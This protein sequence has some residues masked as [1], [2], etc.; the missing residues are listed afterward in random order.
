MCTFCSAVEDDF[1]FDSVMNGTGSSPVMFTFTEAGEQCVNISIAMD[2]LLETSEHFFVVMGSRDDRVKLN[3]HISRIDIIDSG[4][5]F[6]QRTC[7]H[8]ANVCSVQ[9]ECMHVLH[10]YNLC[11]HTYN[12]CYCYPQ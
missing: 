9:Y 11:Y 2:N 6:M 8:I 5:E 7:M 3:N 1:S 12:G 4:S 10:V